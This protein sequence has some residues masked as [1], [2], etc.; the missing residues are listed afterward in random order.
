MN[1]AFTKSTFNLPTC[2]LQPELIQHWGYPV[3]VHNVQTEDGYIL[4]MHRIPQ[5]GR[6]P[7]FLVHGVGSSS[8]TWVY[9]PPKKSLGYL[10]AD[11]GFDVWMGN[12][13]GNTYSRKHV[14]FKACSFCDKFWNFGFDDTGIKDLSAEIDFILEST[15]FE[16]IHFVGHSMG[17]TQYAVSNSYKISVGN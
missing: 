14:I 6:P 9:G 16:K 11:A 13:R 17:G 5:P 4:G 1:E 10:L 8:A 7:V 12:T 3:E 2:T 15:G